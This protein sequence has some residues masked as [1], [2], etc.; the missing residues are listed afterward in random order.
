MVHR[1][2][3]HLKRK[4]KNRRS[5]KKI[6][7][8]LLPRRKCQFFGRNRFGSSTADIAT[9][10]PVLVPVPVEYGPGW[11]ATSQQS[12]PNYFAPYFGEKVAWIQPSSW[13]YANSNGEVQAPDMIIM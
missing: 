5:Q 2:R 1:R 3:S 6:K 10:A 8:G 9:D 13:W 4:H 7:L 11:D 12:Y